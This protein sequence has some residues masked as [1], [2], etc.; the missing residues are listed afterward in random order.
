MSRDQLEQKQDDASIAQEIY[1]AGWRLGTIFIPNSSIDLSFSFNPENEVLIIATQS[2]TVVSQRFQSDPLVEAIGVRKLVD[3]K[4]RCPEA[5]G[6]NQ[7]KLH[8]ELSK[9]SDGI[10]AIECDMNRR[11]FFDRKKLLD[12]TP[13]VDISIGNAETKKLGGWIGRSYTRIAL[14]DALVKNMKQQF[15]PLL[16]S[17]LKR[18][19]DNPPIYTEIESIYIAWK[20][21]E[22]N[23]CN[24]EFFELDFLFICTSPNSA[25]QLEKSL[26]DEL[27]AFLQPLGKNNVHIA[28]LHCGT[29]RDTFLA[30]L[31]GYER[32]SEWDYFTEFGE[33]SHI[34]NTLSF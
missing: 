23:D 26:L 30:Q 32:L 24:G 1:R 22:E 31:D 8:L 17:L 25:D 12:L 14:P 7:R 10:Q 34:L 20:N 9:K 2:C 29:K 27:D 28:H 16:E 5:T 3:Y 21:V 13:N 15:L 11:M 6:K 33:L 4:K 19:T 18:E